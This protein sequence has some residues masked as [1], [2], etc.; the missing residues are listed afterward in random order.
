M[1]FR[2]KLIL[3]LNPTINQTIWTNFAYVVKSTKNAPK[4]NSNSKTKYF[5]KILGIKKNISE[6]EQKMLTQVSI[7][8]KL[9]KMLIIFCWKHPKMVVCD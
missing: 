7:I 1:K 3:T 9:T 8:G 6:I 5:S 2:T 4:E